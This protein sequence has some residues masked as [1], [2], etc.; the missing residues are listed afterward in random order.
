MVLWEFVGVEVEVRR[1]CTLERR[2]ERMEIG[3]LGFVVDEIDMQRFRA[4]GGKYVRP[5]MRLRRRC[6]PT[7]RTV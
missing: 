7:V 6:G 4:L 2:Y 3:F 1:G 5:S